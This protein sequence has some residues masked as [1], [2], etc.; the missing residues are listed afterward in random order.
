M[1]LLCLIAAHSGPVGEHALT[2]PGLG[3][4]PA[5]R[6][7][8]LWAGT[9]L[10]GLALLLAFPRHLSPRHAAGVI[11]LTALLC[12][13]VLLP[14][15][16]SDDINRYLWEGRLITH[17]INP[18][19]HAPQSP[20]LAQLAATDPYQPHVNHP[21]M[22]AAYPPFVL[23]AFAAVTQLWYHPMALKLLII[24]WDLGTLCFLLALLRHRRLDARWAIL[25]AFNPITLF[26]FA[27]QA[28]FDALQGLFLMG[29]LFWYDRR[30]W[31]WMFLFA[32]LAVQSKYAAVLAL[33]LLLRRD[34]LRYAPVAL[35]AIVLPALPFVTSGV[36]P[37]FASLITFADAFAFNGSVHA[38]LAAVL[39]SRE[40]ATLICKLLLIATLLYGWARYTPARRGRFKDDPVPGIFF[41]LGAAL[42]LAPTLHVWYLS[43][44]LPLLVLRPT[45]SWLLLSLTAAFY[46]VTV[47]IA[48]HTGEW[49]LP[50]WAL[51]AEWLPFWLI[52]LSE[53]R[54]AWCHRGTPL[55]T[56]P[57]RSVSIIIPARNEAAR[58]GACVR[59]V[60]QDSSVREVIVVDGGSQD[61]TVRIA[62]EAGARILMHTAPPEAGG[63]RGGQCTA[64]LRIATGD[65]VAIVH[66]D[67]RVERPVFT[68]ALQLLNR[69]ATVVGGAV[70]SCFG[71]LGGPLRMLGLANDFRAAFLGLAFGDQ[72]QFFRREPVVQLNAYPAIPLMEDV[73]LSARLRELGRTVF[74][75]GDADVSA[76]AWQ[77]GRVRRAL[78]IIWL[79]A[80]YRWQRLWKRTNPLAMYR[81]YYAT[82]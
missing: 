50:R 72:V 64:G 43:W 28:H 37:L 51:L 5:G 71:E 75:F 60:L 38:L 61:E 62:R 12:R 27:G 47:G 78:L 79:V 32:G 23:L 80:L 20:E 76:R 2:L 4:L 1:L 6:F 66:A 16:P 52:F 40:S 13:L 65:V 35:A 3:S 55:M 63:G 31:G 81:R 19:G 17:G 33:P 8:A 14:H 25:Y 24:V 30:R 58:I 7:I 44:I 29:A 54:R 73:E 15:P 22:T 11:L 10:L 56:A 49:R 77:S 67:T 74:L 57:V 21:D 42:L 9:W 41:V 36:A 53:A 18:Y 34:N 26:S 69:D 68:Q 70:G 59:S 46:F 45:G 39:H 82:P 48:H